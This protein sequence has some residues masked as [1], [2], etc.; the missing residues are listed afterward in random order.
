V[1][2]A[3]AANRVC[4]EAGPPALSGDG[5]GELNVVDDPA[6][7][8]VLARGNT[9]RR[10]HRR[11]AVRTRGRAG[12]L[13]T[14]HKC[15]V[16][17]RTAGL[18]KSENLDFLSPTALVGDDGWRPKRYG[19]KVRDRRGGRFGCQSFEEAGGKIRADLGEVLLASCGYRRGA[20]EGGLLEEGR[21]AL[22]AAAHDLPARG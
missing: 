3:L 13:R 10:R 17:G 8:G 2:G 20:D 6:A 16:F 14:A 15:P 18:S 21:G 19:M 5:S 9:R 11:A 1:L 12:A 7:Q 4:G 22:Q